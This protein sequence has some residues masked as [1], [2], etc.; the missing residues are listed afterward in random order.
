MKIHIKSFA[1][2]REILGSDLDVDLDQGSTVG[3]LLHSLISS[4][5][6]LRSAILDDAGEIRDHVILMKNRKR[7]DRLEGV[8]TGLAEGDEV[9]ILPPVAGG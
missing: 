2:F 7:I 4:N 6:R 3:D 8:S 9:A 5:P 1:N